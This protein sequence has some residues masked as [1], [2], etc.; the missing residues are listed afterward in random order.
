MYYVARSQIKT[1]EALQSQAIISDARCTI[2]CIYMS[3]VL[4]LSSFIYEVT[5]FAY[6]DAIGAVGI[7]YFSIVEGKE[8][9]E[10]A[11]GN[12]C[13]SHH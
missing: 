7:I 1:G 13:C 5:G 11:K 2:V 6:A 4:L 9:L 8:A 12:E 10:K 3:V